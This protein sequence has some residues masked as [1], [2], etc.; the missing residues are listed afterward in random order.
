MCVC[1]EVMEVIGSPSMERR[2]SLL[3]AGHELCF[4][5]AASLPVISDFLMELMTKWNHHDHFEKV[6]R[7]GRGRVEGKGRGWKK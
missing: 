4:T 2:E 5:H 3:S 7:S 6:S 1:T